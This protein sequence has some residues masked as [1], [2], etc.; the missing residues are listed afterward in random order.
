MGEVEID[1]KVVVVPGV[2]KAQD[3][4]EVQ[5]EMGV[6]SIVEDAILLLVGEVVFLIDNDQAEMCEGLE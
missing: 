5:E 6:Y 1:V 2:V 3:L 4:G